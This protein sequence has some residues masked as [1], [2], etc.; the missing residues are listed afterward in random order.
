VAPLSRD[1]ESKWAYCVSTIIPKG[2]FDSMIA[3]PLW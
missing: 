3:E 1:S 2:D